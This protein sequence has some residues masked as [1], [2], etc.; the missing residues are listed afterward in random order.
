MWD[1]QVVASGYKHNL[2]IERIVILGL[3][4]PG[5]KWSV[6]V[7]GSGRKIETS[8]GPPTLKPGLHATALVL[9]KPDLPVSQEWSVLLQKASVF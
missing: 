1:L 9:R 5:S 6:E 4:K 7:Q 3:G 8:W 2:D